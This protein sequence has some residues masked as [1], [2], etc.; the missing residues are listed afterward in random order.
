MSRCKAASYDRMVGPGGVG[1]SPLLERWVLAHSASQIALRT[2]AAACTG[3]LACLIEKVL[4]LLLPPARMAVAAMTAIALVMDQAPIRR[5]AARPS[6]P[7]AGLVLR[8]AL[9]GTRSERGAF[10]PGR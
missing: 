1:K 10:G 6:P 9:I 7:F 8:R 2:N 5:R 4:L 3:L